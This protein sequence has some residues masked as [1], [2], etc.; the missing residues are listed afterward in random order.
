MINMTMVLCR[1]FIV[2][3]GLPA[4]RPDQAPEIDRFDTQTGC[5]RSILLLKMIE[6]VVFSTPSTLPI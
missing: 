3:A 5:P 4:K 1:L 6:V 2:G